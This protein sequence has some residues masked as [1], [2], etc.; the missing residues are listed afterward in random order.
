MIL[1]NLVRQLRRFRSLHRVVGVTLALF[2]FTI[3]VTGIV[4]GWKKDVQL[5]QPATRKGS[6]VLLR[7]WISLEHIS[8]I[9]QQAA[10]S[11]SNR[12]LQ[13]DRMDVRPDNGIVK[14][15]YKPGY[16]EVQVDGTSGEVLSVAQRHA[17]WIEHI[18]DGSIFSDMF[19]LVYTNIM[20]LGLIT[21]SLSGLW[22]WYGPKVIRKMK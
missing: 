12:N 14:V 21:L 9:A 7:N 16:W 5:L 11:V 15:T 22:L 3:G 1:Q 10:D 18:H 2:F 19:K 8:N 17:D 4:L 13:L 6:G 20:G